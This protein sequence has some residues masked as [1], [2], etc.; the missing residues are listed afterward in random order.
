LRNDEGDGPQCASTIANGYRSVH[1]PGV[2][3]TCT[4]NDDGVEVPTGIIALDGDPPRMVMWYGEAGDLADTSAGRSYIALSDDLGLHWSPLLDRAGV[5]FVFSRGAPA[6]PLRFLVVQPLLVDAADYA[7]S[8]SSPCQLPMP[9]GGDTR[10]LLLFGSGLYRRSDIYLGFVPLAALLDAFEDP[11][12]ADLERAF[13]Y[14]AGIGAADGPGGCWS[15][16]QDDAIPVVRTSDPSP[17]A[18][19][20]APCGNTILRSSS[21][22]GEFS[23]THVQAGDFDRLVLLLNNQY[24]IHTGQPASRGVELVTGEPMRPWIWNTRVPSSELIGD[25]VQIDRPYAPIVIPRPSSGDDVPGYGTVCPS[26]WTV[27]S[28]LWGYGPMLIDA[29]TRESADGLDL[30]FILSRWK[31]DLDLVSG[32]YRVDVFRTTLSDR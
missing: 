10:G 6:A 4:G 25:E 5:P 1:V 23:I 27:E 30:Y 22:A 21:G 13:S 17:H 18:A 19:F 29:Y 11:A 32:P 2:N 26:D 16:D 28:S 15:S 20:E 3:N 8:A 9:S 7:S 31:G 24:A 14:F 12:S